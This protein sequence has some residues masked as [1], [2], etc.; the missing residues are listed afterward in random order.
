MS[1]AL[2]WY[3]MAAWPRR[4]KALLLS[5]CLLLALGSGYGL[6][7]RGAN[8][9]LERALARG[10]ELQQAWQAQADQVA[11]LDEQQARLLGLEQRLREAQAR[12]LPA[13]GMPGLLQAVARAGR[14]L[15]FEQ[16]KVLPA[17]PQ[18]LHA[19]M[20]VHLQVVGDFAALAGFVDALATLPERVTLHDFHLAPLAGRGQ[21]RLQMHLKAYASGLPVDPV[22]Q[23]APVLAEARDPFAA[24]P[25]AALE[26]ALEHVPLEQMELVGHLADRRGGVALIRVAGA[27]YPLREGDRLG[28]DKGRVV[29]IDARQVELEE[30]VWVEG[31]GWVERSQVIEANGVARHV[32]N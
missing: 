7:L 21:L 18:A 10:A 31:A 28:P 19:E 27:L 32:V 16:V 12:L 4:Y 25:P 3:L 26:F 24:P 20:P 2:D 15:V 29:R 17:Q 23:P 6:H 5:A 22:A 1:P 13:G 8:A 14:G 9:S 11:R 30:Q